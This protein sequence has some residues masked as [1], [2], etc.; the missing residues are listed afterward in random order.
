MRNPYRETSIIIMAVNGLETLTRPCIESVLATTA[1]TPAELV[2]I[3]NG[4]T[5]GAG[6]YFRSVQ[7]RCG[8]ARVKVHSF[9]QNLGC[10]P[11]RAKGMEL[12]TRDFMLFLD[13]DTLATRPGWLLDLQRPM[14]EDP[15]I[16]VVGQTGYYAFI[17]N[18]HV[19][20]FFPCPAQAGPCDVVQGYCMMFRAEP[21]R[22]GLVKLDPNYGKLW[23]E[24]S[25]LCMQFRSVGYRTVFLDAGILHLVNRTIRVECGTENDL[26]Q[27]WAERTAYF[28]NKWFGRTTC[29]A[30]GVLAPHALPAT[31]ALA[32][33]K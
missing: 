29:G 6:A 13:N 3:D 10:T 17:Y 24:E 5:D 25:D 19:T 33:R 16:G 12:A 14:L 30:P 28:S 15:T 23:H 20:A 1:D 27:A 2:L 22:Q 32:E 21:H 7:A 18:R 31:H 8:S 26:K 4:S 9:P 11:G